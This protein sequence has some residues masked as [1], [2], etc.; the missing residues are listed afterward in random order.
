LALQYG[1]DRLFQNVIKELPLH[2]A[3]KIAVLEIRR[4]RKE[5]GMV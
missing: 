3:Q 5:A 2:D 4:V 1:I